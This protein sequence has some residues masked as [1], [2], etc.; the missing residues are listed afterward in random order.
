MKTREATIHAE[1][2][3]AA[4]GTAIYPIREKDPISRILIPFGVTVG[5][6][7]RLQH[8]SKC[9][10]KVEIVDGSDVL[11]SLSGDQIDGISRLDRGGCPAMFTGNTRST[12]DYGNLA[13][14]FG[15]Y[16]YDK[17]F[18]FEPAKFKNPQL[19]IT[20]DFTTVEAA[21]TAV[22][23]AAHA[24]LMEGLGSSPRGFFMRKE[25]KSWTAVAAGWEYTQMARDFPYRRLFLQ[26]LTKTVSIGTH[27]SRARLSEDNDARIPFDVLMDD[28]VAKNAEEYGPIVEPVIGTRSAVTD[29]FFAAPAYSG[30]VMVMPL[31]T[32]NGLLGATWD[33]GQYCVS[34]T[35]AGE[36]WRGICEGLCPQGIVAF[37]MGPLDTP[38]DWY[39]PTGIGNLQLEVLGAGAYTIHLLTEQVR[40]NVPR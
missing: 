13:I 22:I 19:K 39:D 21:C 4:A 2:S 15:R 16:L 26:A 31:L 40:P 23:V 17:E 37:H 8:I 12:T 1:E 38:E 7:A 25:M 18:A 6:N 29:L 5:A 30:R 27:W 35:A 14:D 3:Y 24:Y 36:H 28:Q 10:S 9:L 33:G 32:V 11:L 34:A 20:R